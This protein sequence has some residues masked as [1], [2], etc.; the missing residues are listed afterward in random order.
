MGYYSKRHYERL[1]N[2][3]PD[4]LEQVVERLAHRK[5]AEQI[6]Q[7]MLARFPCGIPA[8]SMREFLDWQRSRLVELKAAAIADSEIRAEAQRLLQARR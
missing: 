8:T 7:E 4:A 6:S 1:S 3:A 2:G 5:A